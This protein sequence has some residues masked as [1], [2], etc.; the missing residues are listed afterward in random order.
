VQTYF[1]GSDPV[2]TV[3]FE[4]VYKCKDRLEAERLL[5]DDTAET[6]LIR[7]LQER[8]GQIED[9]FMLNYQK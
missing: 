5:D 1:K 8:Y 3:L 6:E 4:D 2:K 9:L 7:H